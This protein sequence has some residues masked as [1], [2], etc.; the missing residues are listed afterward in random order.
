LVSPP[1]SVLACSRN[2]RNSSGSIDA[3]SRSL[4]GISLR[5]VPGTG[6]AM[7]LDFSAVIVPRG[8]P[9]LFV[10]AVSAPYS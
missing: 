5:P 4:M 9:T 8:L 1:P 6:L 2:A 10:C 3:E 7:G